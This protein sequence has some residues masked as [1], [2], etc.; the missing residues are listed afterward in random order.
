MKTW[1]DEEIVLHSLSRGQSFG[2]MSIIE[3]SP[4]SAT[5]RATTDASFVT[6]SRENFES[7]MKNYPDIGSKI[8]KGISLL[9][10]KYLRQTSSR[11]V[12]YMSKKR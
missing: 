10:S 9:L 12:S 1:T 11:L 6:L 2:E 5:V 8:L 3:N 4:R 7:I